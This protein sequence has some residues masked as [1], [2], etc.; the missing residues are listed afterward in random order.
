MKKR[1]DF[2]FF[3]L[4]LSL[5]LSLAVAFVCSAEALRAGALHGRKRKT[6]ERAKRRLSL[7]TGKKKNKKTA[8]HHHHHSSFS[9]SLRAHVV[10]LESGRALRPTMRRPAPAT[11]VVYLEKKKRWVVFCQCFAHENALCTHARR[12]RRTAAG[13]G[14]T[15]GRGRPAT[16]PQRAPPC[17]RPLPFSASPLPSSPLTTLTKWLPTTPTCASAPA[18][19]ASR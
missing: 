14:R 1:L 16:P 12:V 15:A 19:G 11:R 18:G 5:S 13:R 4:S 7:I 8:N 17:G 2:H 6:G 9:A 3:F 10:M